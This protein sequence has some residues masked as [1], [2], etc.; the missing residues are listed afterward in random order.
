MHGTIEFG[1]N[2]VPFAGAKLTADL[3]EGAQWLNNKVDGIP[4]LQNIVKPF[5]DVVNGFG[6]SIG[7]VFGS[8][9]RSA[10]DF[11]AAFEHL[12]HGDLKEAG[13]SL[14]NSGK[15][16]VVGAYDSTKDAVKSVLDSVED[17]FSW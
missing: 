1:G 15:D 17:F 11:G 4:V 2:L 13:K 5:G 7:D 14:Y 6:A 12:S 16:I 3:Q 9:G 8:F 10:N